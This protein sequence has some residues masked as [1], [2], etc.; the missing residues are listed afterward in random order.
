[1]RPDE[2][3]EQAHELAS[4]LDA[5][6]RLQDKVTRDKEAAQRGDET[7]RTDRAQQHIPRLEELEREE[8]ER[9]ERDRDD[10]D[11]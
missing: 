2:P 9:R 1:R 8:L 6:N 3:A 11:R 4:T 10:R 7:T 5:T